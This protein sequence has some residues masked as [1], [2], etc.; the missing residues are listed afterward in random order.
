MHSS[1]IQDLAIVLGVA[2]LVG[3]LFRYLRQPSILG[4]L[5]AGLIV[6][7]YIPIPIFADPE[8]IHSLSE[9][10][11]VLVMFV[12]GLEFQL[13]RL[14]RVLPTAGLA[15]L[16][17]IG[18]MI[19]IGYLV[20]LSLDWTPIQALFL[21]CGIGISSTMVISK[22]FEEKDVSP[23]VREF[24]FGILVIQDVVAIAILAL[25]TAVAD[26]GN[27][28]ASDLF[29]TT[30][31]LALT[32]V[33]FLVGGLLVV[34]RLVK[35]VRGK[36]SQEALVVTSVGL[37]FGFAYLAES[38]GYSVALGA[39]VAGLLVAES[40][41]GHDVEQQIH[42]IKHMYAAI[43]FVSI[44]MTV[45]PVLAYTN[46]GPAIIIFLVILFGQFVFVSIGGMLSGR[47]LRSSLVAG[48]ALGQIGE[49]S[50]IIAGVGQAV[51]PD[52]LRPILITAAILTTFTTPLFLSQSGRVVDFVDR[53]LP[54]RIKNMLIVY[55]S[56]LE[57][58][59]ATPR[60]NPLS[61]GK[62]ALRAIIFDLLS[63]LSLLAVA[64]VWADEIKAWIAT[65]AHLTDAWTMIV[66]YVCLLIGSIPPLWGI[67]RNTNHL[68]VSM[69][70][71]LSRGSH[72]SDFE[73]TE[74]G[75]S[76][77]RATLRLIVVVVVGLPVAL[78]LDPLLGVGPVAITLVTLLV[79]A[80]TFFWRSAG[81]YDATIRSEAERLVNYLDDQ[82]SEP[83]KAL[84]PAKFFPDFENMEGIFIDSSA[85]AVGQKL[86][87]L[88][89]RA[90]TG[91]LVVLIHR[92][93]GDLAMPKG[94]ALVEADD[95]LFVTGTTES[96]ER[97]RILLTQIEKEE[98]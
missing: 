40:G 30:A 76:F 8:R 24:V 94:T 22:V 48:L 33:A 6:G 62:L 68:S 39:F 80:A 44:G 50:F 13:S 34:P 32:L 37:C 25:L 67:A 60:S 35:T 20:G 29:R 84:N 47:G 49:F 12:I 72:R 16:F 74:F 64:V 46:M 65:K 90:T 69:I 70:T 77:L 95:L 58:L 38:Q 11:V 26:S 71:N 43:F 96:I 27:V 21:G 73:M 89:L 41:R 45:D 15:A 36:T 1:Y 7:P 93:G 75:K 81:R 98:A 5:I 78:L 28:S 79:I 17:Q 87:D 9:L 2:A 56:W 83:E 88:N 91:V 42:P 97:A 19:W 92:D 3:I 18:A 53:N 55:G 4:Y 23:Q 54:T 31:E 63:W 82:R 59:A 61:G 86:A 51:V 14:F 66:F 52:S 10:G 57:G 85:P